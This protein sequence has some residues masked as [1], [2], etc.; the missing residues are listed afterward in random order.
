MVRN[1]AVNIFFMRNGTRQYW[2]DLLPTKRRESAF[3]PNSAIIEGH[4]LT[5]GAELAFQC[6]FCAFQTPLQVSDYEW[7]T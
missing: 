7:V 6:L 5:V 1:R 3:S 4:E 2:T